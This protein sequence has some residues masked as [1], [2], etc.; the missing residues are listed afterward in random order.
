MF[1][2]KYWDAWNPTTRDPKQFTTV[3]EAELWHT[4]FGARKT[5]TLIPPP[6]PDRTENK[7]LMP[8]GCMVVVDKDYL[9]IA[10]GVQVSQKCE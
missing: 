6:F 3:R 1:V 9:F 5:K 8:Q 10:G 7:G 2:A 4:N